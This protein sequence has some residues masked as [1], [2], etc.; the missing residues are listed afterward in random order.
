MA[1][2]KNQYRSINVKKRKKGNPANLFM[3]VLA[4]V[5][6]AFLV[7]YA[8]SSSSSQAPSNS[9]NQAATTGVGSGYQDV[10][11]E[12]AKALIDKGNVAIVDVRTDWEFK[13]GHLEDAELI[14][15]TEIAGKLSEIPKDKPV[16]LYCATG[17]RS[18]AAAALLSGKG[19]T[20]IYNMT[21]GIAQWRGA[22]V[23]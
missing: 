15:D 5:G 23:Q 16:L 3:L 12:E 10:S 13:Q 4:I 21:G 9:E 11:P 6:G 17:S 18:A 1:R 8:I 14:P 2:K 7:G 20:N 22:V 19:Y